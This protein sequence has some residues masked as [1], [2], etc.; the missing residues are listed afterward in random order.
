MAALERPPAKP[1]EAD[2][3]TNLEVGSDTTR[4]LTTTGVVEIVLPEQLP[5]V[6]DPLDPTPAT[7]DSPPPLPDEK[8]AAKVIAWLQVS[9]PEADTSTT[10][11]ARSAGSASTPSRCGR[12]ARP[13]RSCSALGTGDTDQRYPLAH[14]P[15]LPG[16]VQLQVEEVD[17]WSDWQEVETYAVSGPDDR[18]FTFDAAAGRSAS[19]ATAYR[20]SVS[21]FAC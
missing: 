20:S 12:R 4:G 9:R 6:G 15:V 14:N 13:P 7:S 21:R 2:T 5:D 17:D 8:Q 10:S 11:S 1:T 19:P 3:F 16:T 18:H